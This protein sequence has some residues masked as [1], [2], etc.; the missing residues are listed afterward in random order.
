M[1]KERSVWVKSGVVSLSLICV[2]EFLSEYLIG[3]GLPDYDWRYLSISYLGK[4]GSPVLAEVKI[5]AV[6]FTLLYLVFS[7]SL[8]KSLNKR[9]PLIKYAAC[10]LAIYGICE[11]LGSGFFPINAPGT[12]LTQDAFIHNIFGAIGDTAFFSFPVLMLFVFPRKVN[13]GFHKFTF[14]CLVIAL[15]F[16]SFFLIAKYLHITHGIFTYRG[17]WQRAFLFT[18]YI[19]FFGIGK[20]MLNTLTE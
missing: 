11:G 20:M 2:G 16:C 19:Y 4:E 8:Y 7:F 14:I 5:W 15:V 18:F 17:I 10:L 13:P 3:K 6:L 1:E 9:S 12:P